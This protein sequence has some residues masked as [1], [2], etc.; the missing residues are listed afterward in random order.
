[1]CH[2]IFLYVR[3]YLLFDFQGYRNTTMF[4]FE[5][6]NLQK[7][8]SYNEQ[9][10]FRS[11][12]GRFPLRCTLPLYRSILFSIWRPIQVSAI[13]HYKVH[14]PFFYTQYFI[15]ITFSYHNFNIGT[16]QLRNRSCERSYFLN[17]FIQSDSFIENSTKYILIPES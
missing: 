2:E 8:D 10:L 11:S 4:F 16:C 7:P 3:K 17:V 6:Q 5:V 14:P 15:R 1:M 13:I 12:S 9:Q